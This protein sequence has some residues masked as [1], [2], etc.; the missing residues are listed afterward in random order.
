MA[1]LHRR[2]GTERQFTI[3]LSFPNSIRERK[4][5]IKIANILHRVTL[6]TGSVYQTDTLYRKFHTNQSVVN[7]FSTF[8]HLFFLF[9]FLKEL[10]SIFLPFIHLRFAEKKNRTAKKKNDDCSFFLKIAKSHS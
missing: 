7:D 4:R 2:S 1:D 5:T 3:I 10:Y 8:L 6:Q 9:C